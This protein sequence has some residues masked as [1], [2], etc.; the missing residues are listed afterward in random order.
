[1]STVTNFLVSSLPDYVEQNRDQIIKNFALVGTDTRKRIGLQTGVKGSA[2]LN[3]LALAATLQDGSSCGFNPL[4]EITLSQRTLATA[5]IKTDGQICPETLIG[6]YAEYLVRVAATEND[7]PF[8]QYIVEMLTREVNKKIE[9]LIWLGDHT[10]SSD[11]NIKW[12]DG[13]IYKFDNDAD[14]I[15]VNI[16]SGKTAYE[17]LVEVYAQMPEETLERGGMIFVSPA[18]YRA[19][20]MDMVRLNYYHYAGA[21]NAAPEEFILPGT[22]VKVVKTP[23]LAG[24]LK[25]V[26]TFADNL[27][28]GCDAEN[29]EEKVDIWWSNDDRLFKYQVKWNMG[30]Q[31]HFP[32]QVVLGAFA[33]TPA[34]TAGANSALATI[35]ANSANIKD[36]TTV[37]GNVK[38]DLD[39]IATKSAGLDNLAGIKSDNDAIAGCVDDGAI[40]TKTAA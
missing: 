24:S 18:I 15:D 10:Q 28:Y 9:K 23:G 7:L 1:M 13:F 30:V 35:A 12:I 19:F 22:D 37:L 17:G 6:K 16:T 34:A 21:Q 36:Y 3:Y 8:E 5:I 11:A 40:K 29:D 31:Y 26:G 2:Y 33:A 14:V 39:T 27:V 4:D 38:S 32:A 25:I 20:L